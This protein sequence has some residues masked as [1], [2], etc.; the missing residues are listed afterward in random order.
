M[1]APAQSGG[2][3]SIGERHAFRRDFV[4]SMARVPTILGSTHRRPG[5]PADAGFE[6]EVVPATS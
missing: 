5:R 1:P 3:G 2:V 6:R 4:D